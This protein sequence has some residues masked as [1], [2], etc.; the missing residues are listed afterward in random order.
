M[1]NWRPSTWGDE[2][3]LNYG[4]AIRGYQN[5]TKGFRV[6]GSNGAV[7]WHDEPLSDGPGVI[8]GRKGA[9]RGV[10]YSP[11]P[12]YVIDTAYYVTPKGEMD[13]RWLYYA[14]KYHRLGE[15]DDGSP[16]PST[17]RA[18]VYTREFDV[19]SIGEQK[20]IA[21]VLAC[22]DD[23]I[24]INRRINATLEE[25]ARAIFRDWF[26]DFGPV[27]RKMAMSRQG[28]KSDPV[29]ILGGLVANC[30]K[31]ALLAE[32]FPDALGDDGLPVGWENVRLGDC[33]VRLKVGKLYDQKS[34]IPYGKI[35]I[36]DQGKSGVIGYHNNEPNI[37]ASADRR[38]SIFANHTCL[39]R[40]LDFD[41][42]TIQNVIP[43]VGKE[44]P[45]EWV[46]FAS[47]GKQSFEEYRGHWP[48]FVLNKVVRPDVHIAM[49]FKDL[50]QPLLETISSNEAA[51]ETL[52]ETRDYLL[53]CLMSRKMTVSNA[54]M[55]A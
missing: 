40:I 28:L 14:I 54:E 24:E 22:L 11:D 30:A 10:E 12:F 35:P 32:S 18:A 39:Q 16:I 34:A 9:Y 23:K 48:S 21:K 38:V 45:T 15:I 2:V 25:M 50:I 41:F 13:M 17:T 6:F 53:P 52:A 20:A 27:Q 44:L 36:L 33:L 7:G 8:L 49:E 51:N 29:A 47:L 1:S 4:K 5:A 19:P 3:T 37:R 31:A 46:H 43:F 55:M 42:S 26:V